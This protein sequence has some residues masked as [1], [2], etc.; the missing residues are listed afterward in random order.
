MKTALNAKVP[1]E[2][3]TGCYESLAVSEGEFTIW[4]SQVKPLALFG[5][6]IQ[7]PRFDLAKV[8]KHPKKWFVD[9]ERQCKPHHTTEEE[10]AVIT[11]N[12]S[13]EN[14]TIIDSE[15]GIEIGKKCDSDIF[16]S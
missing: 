6:Y 2:H 9:G 7:N 10:W 1:Y 14:G 3:V 4:E 5:A 12:C 15:G 13:Y 11:Q 16:L 8:R